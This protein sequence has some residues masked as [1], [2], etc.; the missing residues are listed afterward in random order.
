VAFAVIVSEIGGPFW[1]GMFAVFPAVFT[2]TVVILSLR[3]GKEFTQS[4]GKTII[5]ST[6]VNVTLFIL[7]CR[8][9]YPV[10]GIFLGT[11]LGYLLSLISGVG[12]YSFAKKFMK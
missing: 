4:V 9:A 12:V 2:S 3:Q 8:Y 11:A 6:A 5:L 10:Y 1:G 7:V